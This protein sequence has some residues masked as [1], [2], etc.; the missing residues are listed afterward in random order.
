MKIRIGFVSNS[1]SSSFVIYVKYLAGEQYIK[2]INYLRNINE[3]NFNWTEDKDNLT[4]RGFTIMD[5]DYFGS[6]LQT[7]DVN[8]NAIIW[9][10]EYE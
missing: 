6:F 5:N 7:L 1:S 9:D 8:H 4:I 10:E 3:D 2:I